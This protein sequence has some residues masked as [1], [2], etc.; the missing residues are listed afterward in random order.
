M[1]APKVETASAVPT[2]EE[3]SEYSVVPFVCESSKPKVNND[4][5]KQNRGLRGKRK[6]NDF[7]YVRN[8]EA[9]MLEKAVD[10][11]NLDSNNNS[12]PVIDVSRIS[13]KDDRKSEIQDEEKPD[14]EVDDNHFHDFQEQED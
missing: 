10:E 6:I 3:E 9:H 7:L 5:L 1:D 11:T 13:S 12:I 14:Q 8:H 2:F 4:H